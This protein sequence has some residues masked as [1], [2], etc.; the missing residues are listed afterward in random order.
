MIVFTGNP[1]IVTPELLAYKHINLVREFNLSSP[2]NYFAPLRAL[3]GIQE[4]LPD[5]R[6]DGFDEAYRYYIANNEEARIELLSIV[7]VAYLGGISVVL[8]DDSTEFRA[9]INESLA[10]VISTL[11]GYP[12][13]YAEEPH[14]LFFAPEPDFSVIGLLTFDQDRSLLTNHMIG[15]MTYDEQ[16]RI[17]EQS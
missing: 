6:L 16:R 12:V 5:A 14:E 10:K 8:I 13:T 2:L 3:L 7:D 1:N 4:T 15:E 9:L 17:M 11:Y